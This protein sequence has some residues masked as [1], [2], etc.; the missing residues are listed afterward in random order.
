MCSHDLAGSATLPLVFFLLAS[1][2]R[3]NV[4]DSHTHPGDPTAWLAFLNTVRTE[5]FDQV[6]AIE[7]LM[8]AIAQAA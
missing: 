1:Q 3:G 7:A 4:A 2:T 5:W 6:L 8:P